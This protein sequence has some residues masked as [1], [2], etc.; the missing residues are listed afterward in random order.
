MAIPVGESIQT[1][2]RACSELTAA[3]AAIPPRVLLD[4]FSPSDFPVDRVVGRLIAAA[5]IAIAEDFQNLS[6]R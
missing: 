6:N 4:S 2:H 3:V 5:L 1:V